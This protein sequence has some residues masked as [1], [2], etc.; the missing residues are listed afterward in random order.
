[1]AIALKVDLAPYLSLNS[2]LFY[3][4]RSLTTFFLI[5]RQRGQGHLRGLCHVQREEGFEGGAHQQ[6]KSCIC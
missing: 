6:T 3:I 1:M 5:F 2:L 4:T